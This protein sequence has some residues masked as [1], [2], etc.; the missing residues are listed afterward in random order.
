MRANDVPGE[1]QSRGTDSDRTRRPD[2]PSSGITAGSGITLT[3]APALELRYFHDTLPRA[4]DAATVAR[5][6]STVV[7]LRRWALS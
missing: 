5:R 7:D 6:S 1:D 4:A 3:T 2:Y